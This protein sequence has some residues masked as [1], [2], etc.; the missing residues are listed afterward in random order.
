MVIVLRI[1]LFWLTSF[2]IQ[3]SL[4]LLIFSMMYRINLST[5]LLIP[6]IKYAQKQCSLCSCYSPWCTNIKANTAT[7]S[8]LE[9]HN[10]TPKIT[11]DSIHDAQNKLQTVLLK[12]TYCPCCPKANCKQCCWYS[13]CIKKQAENSASNI[14]HGAQK[15]MLS[16]LKNI[17]QRIKVSCSSTTTW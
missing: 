1:H 14:L 2:N 16:V 17:N 7:Y 10:Q 4:Q 6:I 8:L 5:E 12:P 3:F 13:P 11:T 9:D 15:Q